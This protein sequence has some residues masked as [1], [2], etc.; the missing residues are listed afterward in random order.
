MPDPSIEQIAQDMAIL[1]HQMNLLFA[2]LENVRVL[3]AV[4]D[5][6]N[7]VIGIGAQVAPPMIEAAVR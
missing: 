6:R 2:A 4:R 1:R 3:V 7:D 5:E